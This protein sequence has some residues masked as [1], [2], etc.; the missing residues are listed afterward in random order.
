MVSL[1]KEMKQLL[2]TGKKNYAEYWRVHWDLGAEAYK[3][4]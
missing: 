2:N 3:R 4:S 1:I